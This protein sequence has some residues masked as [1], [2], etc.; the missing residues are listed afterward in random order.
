MHHA[1][2]ELAGFGELGFQG[3]D[4]GVHVEEDGGYGG[5]FGEERTLQF[6]A[7]EIGLYNVQKTVGSP[8]FICYGCESRI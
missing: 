5:L 6:A 3:G 1:V 4:L 2:L 7:E 8:S